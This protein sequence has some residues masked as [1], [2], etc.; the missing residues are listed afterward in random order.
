[1]TINF[2]TYMHH[3]LVPISNDYKFYYVYVHLFFIFGGGP[4]YI[5]VLR[6]PVSQKGA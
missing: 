4:C 2:I 3:Y 5:V 6:G 1:M